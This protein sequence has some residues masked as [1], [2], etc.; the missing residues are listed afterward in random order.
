MALLLLVLAACGG[1]NTSGDN[2]DNANNNN[3]VKN[4]ENNVENNNN[5]VANEDTNENANANENENAGD[6]DVENLNATD[7][8]IVEEEITLSMFA[9]MSMS[10]ER[11]WDD[12]LIWNEYEEM[13]GIH[14]DFE[15][16]PA[17]SLE[18]KRNLALASG[19]LPDVFYAANIPP[20]DL[21]K[22]GEQGT[23]I[24]L[25]DLIDEYAPNLTA[26]LEEN[27]EIKKGMTFPDGNIYS[28]PHIWDPGFTSLRTNPLPWIDEETLEHVGMEN[29]ETIDDFYD[30]L[31]AVQE[32]G[33]EGQVP[34]GIPS[35]NYLHYWLKGAYD[36]GNTGRELIDKDP[37]TGDIRFYATADN[38]KEMLEFTHKLFEEELIEQ[39]LYTL[40][41]D[42]FLANGAEGKY[43]TTVFYSPI[44]LFG[45]E[46]GSKYIG[47]IPLEGPHG[48]QKWVQYINPLNSIGK[49]AIT[50]ENEHP[51][52]SVRWA[53][54]FY[55]DE[56]AELFYMGVEGETF[57]YDED[58]DTKYVD[59]ITDNPDG[60][61][62]EQELVK[63]LAWVGLG[64]PGILKEEFFDGSEATPQPMEAAEGLEPYLIDE[65]WPE[66]TYTADEAKVL[67]STGADIQKYSEEM[68]DKFITGD[69]PFS[70]WD[71]YVETLDSM[72]LDEYMEIQAEAYGRYSEN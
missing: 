9:S 57:E 65:P 5:E 56:G 40:E 25:N 11:N 39:N 44:D 30:F 42:Q 60:T 14:V 63:Y 64:A 32:D 28:L 2:D 34:L 67:S 46:I 26:L 49:F 20:L 13:T 69:V 10:T 1:S 38:Y 68:A 61:T 18:E 71:N 72:G 58:G 54:H 33:P 8:P 16:T 15:Q 51:E 6:S 50:S 53:D 36:V 27:P 48:D 66:F 31:V 4:E 62:K 45:E 41:W 37:E 21:F 70:E 29:P 17:D 22:Y 43:A 52:A 23:F 7:M 19:T 59:K 24:P 55:G 47:G 35:M 3:D 12:I